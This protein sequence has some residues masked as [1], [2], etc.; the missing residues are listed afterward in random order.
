MNRACQTA[1]IGTALLLSVPLIVPSISAAPKFSE[2]SAPVNLGPNIN[3]AFA[4]SGALISKDGL[5]LYFNSNRP[6]GVGNSDLWLSRRDSVEDSWGPP[7][8]LG[9]TI[10]STFNDIVPNLSRDGHYLFFASDRPGGSGDLDLWVSRREHTHEDFGDFGWQSPVNLGGIVNTAAI[11][12]GP[13]Y[14]ENEGSSAP[15]LFFASDRS[16]GPGGFDIYVSELNADGSFDAGVFVTELNTELADQAPD[17]THDGLEMFI[18]SNRT[19]TIGL[20]DLWVS[21]RNTTFDMWSLPVNLGS[22]VNTAFNEGQPSL[23]SDRRT[24]YF[25]SDRPEGSGGNDLYMTTRTKGRK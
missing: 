15:L 1:S 4:E 5:T 7:A 10:N 12:A 11:D 13:S 8:N 21:T 24:L 20:A 3:S 2:W 22:L 9:A 19:G 18:M 16:G 6:G 25:Y 17:V 23:S 14:F